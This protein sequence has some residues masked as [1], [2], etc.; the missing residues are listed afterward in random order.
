MGKSKKTKNLKIGIKIVGVIVAFVVLITILLGALSIKQSGELLAKSLGKTAL[1]SVLKARE[2]IN[3]DAFNDIIKSGDSSSTEYTDI[4]RVLNEIKEYAGLLYLYTMYK[5]AEG[6][7]RYAIDGE[8]LD[9][10]DVSELGDI[11]EAGISDDMIAAFEGSE[12]FGDMDYTEE[13]GWTISAYAPIKDSGGNV[14]GIV[15]ADF[16]GEEAGKLLEQTRIL[17]AIGAIVL[18]FVGMIV[19][20]LLAKH[21]A[22]PIMILSEKLEK[23]ETGQLNTVIKLN[24]KDEFASLEKSFNNMTRYLCGTVRNIRETSNKLELSSDNMA[25]ISTQ[26]IGAVNDICA[27]ILESCDRSKL[28][29][30]T[31][32]EAGSAIEHTAKTADDLA[33]DSREMQ[34]SSKEIEADAV[35]G[36]E[37]MSAALNEIRELEGF[38]EEAKALYGKLNSNS[39]DI[40]RI[41]ETIEAIAAQTNMLAINAS[42]EAARAG[43]QGKGFAVVANEVRKLSE[44][45][46]AATKQI[47]SIIQSLQNEICGIIE[48][49]EREQIKIDNVLNSVVKTSDEFK[50]IILK[51][52]A[53]ADKTAKIEHSNMDQALETKEL[54][55]KL[56]YIYDMEYE[57]LGR[58]EAL[59]TTIQQMNATMQ[60]LNSLAVTLSSMADTLSD[61]VKKFHI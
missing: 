24:R 38:K 57:S 47:S 54:N 20:Y 28:I 34:E 14:I 4:R 43:E 15:G 36:G 60:E 11:E 3:A 40:G 19:G 39:Q 8:P 46:G 22:A 7:Y 33:H 12:I 25:G 49:R 35:S 58:I 5:D 32:K 9:S 59:S 17:T 29:T 18:V 27:I 52:K 23:I 16:N 61:N 56:K 41:V 13:Y 55:S 21:V 53:T 37:H 50:D 31:V 44:N 30:E 26:S 6:S 45:T 1:S 42:I 10:D 2:Y 51:I 48:A